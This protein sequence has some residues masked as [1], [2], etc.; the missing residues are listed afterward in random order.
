MLVIATD[1]RRVSSVIISIKNVIKGSGKMWIRTVS[2][3]A[4]NHVEVSSSVMRALL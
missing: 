1:N 2:A 3:F 4:I